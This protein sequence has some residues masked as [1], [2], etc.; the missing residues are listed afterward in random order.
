MTSFFRG[1]EDLFVNYLFAPYDFFRLME[2]WW[3][4]NAVNWL[5]FHHRLGS[6]CLLDVGIEKI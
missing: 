4:S 6:F 1:I 2:N 5:F 3:A